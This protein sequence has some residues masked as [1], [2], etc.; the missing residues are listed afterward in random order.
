VAEL[1]VVPQ[2]AI[3]LALDTLKKEGKYRIMIEAGGREREWESVPSS[4][5]EVASR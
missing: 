3:K 4:D 5:W 1:N 2:K